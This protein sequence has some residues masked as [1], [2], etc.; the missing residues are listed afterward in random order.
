[1]S[2][3]ETFMKNLGIVITF[4]YVFMKA[5]KPLKDKHKYKRFIIIIY[6]IQLAVNIGCV[7]TMSIELLEVD[8][9]NK[10]LKSKQI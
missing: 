3:S 9:H 6:F 4:Y 2:I 10:E 5:S 7:I 1:M 8:E